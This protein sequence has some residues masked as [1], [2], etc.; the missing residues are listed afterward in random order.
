MRIKDEFRKSGYFWLPFAPERKIPGTL[1]ISDGGKITLEAIG[2][3]DESIEGLSKV[4]NNEYELKRIIGYIEK[5]GFVTLEDCFYKAYNASFGG[6]SKASIHVHKA[7]VGVAYGD[8]EIISFNEFKFSVEGIDEWV[9]VSGIKIESEVESRK[10]SII[11][12]PPKEISLNLS[13]GMNL[14]I[15]FSWSLPGFPS[16]KEAKIIQKTYFKVTSE[17]KLPLSDFISAAYKITTLL[18]FAIDKTVCIE[19]VSA[20]SDAIPQDVDNGQATPVSISLFYQSLPYTEREPKIDWDGMLFR[21]FQIREYAERIVNNWFD[22]Y[23]K[24]DPA[25]NLYFSAKTGDHKYLEGRF[26]ALA[27]GLETYHRRTSSDKLFDE[28]DFKELTSRLIEQC[29]KEKQEWLSGRLQHGNELSL[30]RRIKYII[31]PFK[32]I[33]GTCKER[34]KLIRAIVSTRNYLT[35]YDTSLESESVAGSDLYLLCRKMEAIFQLHLLQVLG[36]TQSEVNSIFEN[37]HE[38]KRKL[39]EA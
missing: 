12:E 11:F 26:L 33:V 15:T 32:E 17:Q 27:Q 16:Q 7:F 19:D 38:L 30:S 37:S 6:V 25:L 22:A 34:R 23:D 18:C 35:H 5:H 24:I 3:F 21:F 1:M 20:T 8:K 14:L 10:A 28:D 9:G 4:I 31:E 29:P 39:K 2:L 13:G 36:F